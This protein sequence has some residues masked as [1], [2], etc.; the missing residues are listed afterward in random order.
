[1]RSVLSFIAVL[2]LTTKFRLKSKLESV[3][4]AL[5]LLTQFCIL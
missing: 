1:M 3:N 2:Y 4:R 5:R